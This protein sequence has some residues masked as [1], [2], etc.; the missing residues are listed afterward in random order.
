[1]KNLKVKIIYEANVVIDEFE[2][3]KMTSEQFERLK[4]EVK[5]EIDSMI[6]AGE[7]RNESSNIDIKW[8]I[9]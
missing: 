5:R 6:L 1:M 2:E 3:K 4:E 8:G 7:G 9:E